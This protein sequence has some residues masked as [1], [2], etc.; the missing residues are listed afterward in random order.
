MPRSRRRTP[1]ASLPLAATV[2]VIA[3]TIIGLAACGQVQPTAS[4]APSGDVAPS[5]SASTSPFQ[6]TAYPPDGDAPC[7]QVQAPDADHAAYAGAI[8]RIRAVDLR[9][10]EFQLC[11]PDVAF[12]TRLASA[13]F[14]VNDTA[15]LESHIDPDRGGEQE[16]VHEVNGT[17]PYRLDSWSRGSEITMVRNETY[18]SEPARTERLIV[19]WR[20]DAAGRLSDLQ[21]GSVDG[22]DDVGPD[23]VATVER[24]AALQ[25]VPRA[26]LNVFYVGFNNTYAPFDDPLVRQA[27]AMG[28]DRDRIVQT[29]YPP[30]SEVASHF[31]P[32]AIYYGCAGGP[33]Y[34]FDPSRARQLLAQAGFP[35]GFGTTIQYR[36]V[37]RPY[38]LDPTAVALELQAQLAAN[39][40][41]RAELV[42]LPEET[43]L[44]TID[45][46]R[47]DG[48]HLLGRSSSIPE[49]SDLLDP[50]FGAGATR[51][52]GTPIDALAA[53]LAAGT[54]TN[55]APTRTAAY[56]E[57][58]SAIRA[59]VPMIPVAHAGSMTAYRSDVAGAQSSPVR[60]ERFAAM[61][62]GD[63]LQFV[64]L[65]DHEPAGLYCADETD[66]VAQLVCSQLTEGLY[67]FA[68]G[69]AAAAPALAQICKPNPELTIWTC[70]LRTGVRF[71]DGATLDAND[72]V[73]SSAAQWDA[74]HPLHRGREGRFEPFIDTFGGL[75]NPPRQPG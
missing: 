32:C 67:A 55:D 52:F 20:N 61:A 8:R 39:L 68:P 42:V 23:D 54:S 37:A 57:A 6:P 47:S 9:T 72:V 21:R 63:R 40:G 64:W 15:W 70:S 30:G 17:G 43:F 59:N 53:A 11:A 10:V 46:G 22:I 51:E 28:I 48:I 31:A 73:L 12:P 34:Q 66:A 44:A 1:R 60:Q 19:R 65:A 29:L 75:L 41:I 4:G 16:I 18:W 50:H 13:A 49:I 7:D 25:A 38:L 58:T 45:E 27:I 71:H 74:E 36:D 2:V 56:R 62:P 14:A 33:W 24:D 5:A 26:G 69:S 35:D 3:A